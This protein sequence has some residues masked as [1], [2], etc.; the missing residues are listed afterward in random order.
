MKKNVVMSFVLLLSFFGLNDL[1]AKNF[2]LARITSELDENVT[3]FFVET[4]EENIIQSLR[5]ITHL[6]NGGI[7]EDVTVQA[8]TVMTEGA[9]ISEH[10]GYDAVKLKVENFNTKTGG[11]VVLD[12]L[13]N[14]LKK[15]RK[16]K[17]IYLHNTSQKAILVDLDKPSQ[18]INRMFFKVNRS[19]P[20]GVVGVKSVETYFENDKNHLTHAF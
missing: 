18:K 14:G 17:R 11:T 9:V 13:Y 8:E 4:D 16:S 19:F 10:N 15:V 5:Y 1:Q 20:I 3:E 2:Q 7:S 6:P 12:Y